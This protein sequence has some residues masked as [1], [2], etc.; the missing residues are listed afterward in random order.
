MSPQLVTLGETMALVAGTGT[1]PF[2]IGV[3]AR[4]SFAG[5]ETNVAIGL[6]RLGHTAGWIGRLGADAMG[7]AI[8]DALRAE[9]VDVSGV[10]FED[11]VPTGLMLREHRTADRVRVT[12]YRAALAGARLAPADVDAEQVRGAKLLHICGITPAISDSA[13]AACHQAVEIAKDAGVR[14]SFDL[15]YRAKLWSPAEATP[16]LSALVRQSDI[17]FAGVEEAALVVGDA[18]AEDQA[19][20]LAEL[21]PNEVVIKLAAEGALA[22]VA[23]KTVTAPAA[24]V[25]CIDPVGAGDAFVAGYLSAVLDE[26]PPEQRVARGNVCGGFAVSVSGDWEGLPRRDELDT[27]AGIDNVGR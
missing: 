13:R 3:P 5:A 26:L 11:D 8:R 4:I 16:E 23:Q 19:A 27:F 6:S 1:G 17:V 25:T 15:N 2:T 9:N 21:G 12:Y 18:S 24:P 7:F 22:V 14:V 20:A 10:R